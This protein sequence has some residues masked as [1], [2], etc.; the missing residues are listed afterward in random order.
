MDDEETVKVA[1]EVASKEPDVSLY[2]LALIA[3]AAQLQEADKT[4][5]LMA[6]DDSKAKNA[7]RADAL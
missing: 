3:L 1:A 6:T 5:E 7:E 2:V 4:K